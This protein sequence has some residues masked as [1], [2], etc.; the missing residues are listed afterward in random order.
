MEGLFIREY[1]SSDYCAITELWNRTGLGGSQRGDNQQT[2][3][4]SIEL[5]GKMLVAL[6]ENL[7]IVA[8]SWMTFDGRRFHLHHFG[9]MPAFQRKG[10]GRLLAQRSIAVAKEQ[11]IQIKL[12]VHKDNKAAINLYKSLGFTYLGDY[13]VYIIRNFSS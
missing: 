10:I 11:N 4:K 13:L 7:E 1:Q 8:T 9:V 3:E 6:T 2:I 5:G 12:E